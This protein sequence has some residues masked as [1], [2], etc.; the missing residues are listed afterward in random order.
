MLCVASASVRACHRSRI[1]SS[2]HT[3]QNPFIITREK[4]RRKMPMQSNIKCA[5]NRLRFSWL[6]DDKTVYHF[7]DNPNLWHLSTVVD[8]ARPFRM[9][10]ATAAQRKRNNM[11]QA[12]G[13]R[14]RRRRHKANLANIKYK[15]NSFSLTFKRS[16]SRRLQAGVCVH[17]VYI[18][19]ALAILSFVRGIF[20]VRTGRN[21]LVYIFS[22]FVFFRFSFFI[23]I[24]LYEQTEMIPSVFPFLRA[25]VVL[26]LLWRAYGRGSC[27]DDGLRC[28]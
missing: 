8:D 20:P 5:I 14:R 12:V 11:Q 16:P 18:N 9:R 10:N 28:K 21:C 15:L 1:L 19:K 25:A 13:W 17:Q 4:R 7:Y 6:N 3:H 2:R 24:V 26:C 23:F 22:L 27:N